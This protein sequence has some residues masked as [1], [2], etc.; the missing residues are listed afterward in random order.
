MIGRVFSVGEL[1][2]GVA[3]DNACPT[4]SM[5]MVTGRP[6]HNSKRRPCETVGVSSSAFPSLLLFSH[7]LLIVVH[8]PGVAAGRQAM[9]VPVHQ[10]V[11]TTR[12][13]T[14]TCSALNMGVAHVHCN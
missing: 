9:R 10:C 14:T 5:T 1:E 3:A 8:V 11:I 2:N 4:A 13:A 12:P 6:I 7:T